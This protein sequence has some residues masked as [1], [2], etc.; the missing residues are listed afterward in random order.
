MCPSTGV[1]RVGP[2]REGRMGGWVGE[3]PFSP[4]SGLASFSP[5][6]SNMTIN[7]HSTPRPMWSDSTVERNCVEVDGR[8]G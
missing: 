2:R 4:L 3:W 5:Q 7:F 1:K 6:L 8:S